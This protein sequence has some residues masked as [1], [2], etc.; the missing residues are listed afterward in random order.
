MNTYNLWDNKDPLST[1]YYGKVKIIED[2][3]KQGRIKVSLPEIFGES[4]PSETPW[5]YPIGYNSGVRLFNVPDVDTEVG[6]IFIGDIYTGFYGIGRYPD[7]QPKIFDS[8]YPYLYGIE[9][10]QGNSVVI[11][12]Q[13]GLLSIRHISGSSLSL[14]K[15]GNLTGTATGNINTSTPKDC[16]VSCANAKVTAQS[17]AEITC[18]QIKMVGDVTIDGNV[19]ILKNTSM[20]GTLTVDETC[21]FEN[22]EW[23]KHKHKCPDGTTEG[24]F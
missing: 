22:I 9:D 7:K 18:P 15:E 17:T 19:S 4:E 16:V 5:I 14:D 21:T 8:E 10:Y 11:N 24:P 2:P 6:I 1:I 20:A 23:K 12:K 3:T 13:T